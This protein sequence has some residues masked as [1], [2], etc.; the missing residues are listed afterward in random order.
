M[1]RAPTTSE[2]LLDH[3]VKAG[4]AARVFLPLASMG[5]TQS[6]GK[7]SQKLLLL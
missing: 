1:P 7:L 3:R 6:R 2:Q 4:S 5:V